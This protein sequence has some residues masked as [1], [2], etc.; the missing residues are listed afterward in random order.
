MEG[1]GALQKAME[2]RGNK[3]CGQDKTGP[4]GAVWGAGEVVLCLLGD[5]KY[6]QK[7]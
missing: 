7:S 2:T 3:R 6:K 4:G 1:C 5:S